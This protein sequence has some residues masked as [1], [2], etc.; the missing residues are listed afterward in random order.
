MDVGVSRP[1]SPPEDLVH[2]TNNISFWCVAM[3]S[4]IKASTKLSP[5]KKKKLMLYSRK[6][7]SKMAIK[8][9]AT[10]SKLSAKVEST[11]DK[12][13]RAQRR[14]HKKL[15][16]DKEDKVAKQLWLMLL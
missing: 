5:S 1:F 11:K 16:S 3:C 14:H 6:K 7:L 8:K 9:G 12:F 4:L 15:A 13:G 2:A 10:K